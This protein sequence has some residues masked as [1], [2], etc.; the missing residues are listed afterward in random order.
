M[1]NCYSPL[2]LPVTPLNPFLI[3]VCRQ[4]PDVIL[5]MKQP[6]HQTMVDVSKIALIIMIGATQ[7]IE[8][9]C[10]EDF[11][12]TGLGLRGI[13]EGC[14]TLTHVVGRCE[15]PRINVFAKRLYGKG[16][17]FAAQEVVQPEEGVVGF[18]PKG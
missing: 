7:F 16:L 1:A 8:R 5:S 17:V 6:V 4:P 12:N 2:S 15:C 13:F 18:A 11:I 14:C 10:I 9:H 3:Q